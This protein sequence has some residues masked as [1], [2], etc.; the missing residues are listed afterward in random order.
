MMGAGTTPQ[1]TSVSAKLA[2]LG[3]DRDIA[4]RDHADPAAIAGAVHQGDGGLG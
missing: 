3:R 1:R 4:T 2:D